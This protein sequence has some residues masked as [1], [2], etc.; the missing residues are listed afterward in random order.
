MFK[1]LR[2]NKTH[3]QRANNYLYL[4]I[5]LVSVIVFPSF[6][7]LFGE[8]ARILFNIF[9]TIAV[10][11]GTYIT[12]NS[13]HTLGIGGV[14]GF[15]TLVSYWGR[16]VIDQSNPINIGPLVISI[17]FFVFLAYN[18]SKSLQR[19]KEVSLNVILGA[20]S[21]FLLIGIIAAQT[22]Q[23]LDYAIPGSYFSSNGDKSSYQYYYF[24]FVTLTTLGYGD[25]TPTNDPARALSVLI[26]VCGQVYTTILIAILIGKYLSRD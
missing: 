15:F 3:H 8:D 13:W 6:G 25:I 20:V 12:T 21:G 18:L 24:S 19:S 16:Y 26:A 1:Y 11:T 2:Y 23:I 22:C 9:F 14:L 7:F 10:L 4:L 17:A 5:S